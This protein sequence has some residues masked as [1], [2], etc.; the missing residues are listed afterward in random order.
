MRSQNSHQLVDASRLISSRVAPK[1]VV[2]ARV[3]VD[4]TKP[5]KPN[6][7]VGVVFEIEGDERIAF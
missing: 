5:D 3:P 4:D 2:I 1:G 7:P 6:E